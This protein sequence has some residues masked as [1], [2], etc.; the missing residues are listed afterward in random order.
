MKIKSR[1]LMFLITAVTASL[2]LGACG[3]SNPIRVRAANE[4]RCPEEN[5]LI[6][7]IGASAFTAEGCGQSAT[8]VCDQLPGSTAFVPQVRCSREAPMP[9][10]PQTVR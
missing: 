2:S 4:F 8:Y 9:S 6:T 3:A 10:G 7:S 5:V 1:I